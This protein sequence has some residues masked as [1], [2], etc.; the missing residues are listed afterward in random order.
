MNTNKM[1][2]DNLITKVITKN[3]SGSNVNYNYDGSKIVSATEYLFEGN[4]TSVKLNVDNVN[5]VN[6]IME[7]KYYANNKFET[8]YLVTPSSIIKN[9][10][11]EDFH[12]T[13]TY[14]NGSTFEVLQ[15]GEQ[16][17]T[18][19]AY[20]IQFNYNFDEIMTKQTG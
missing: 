12:L 9:Q 16:T 2:T 1:Y 15:S 7:R 5:Y 11:I 3:V 10:L 13:E 19:S 20:S 14:K 8:N 18:D 4:S 17:F 6:S